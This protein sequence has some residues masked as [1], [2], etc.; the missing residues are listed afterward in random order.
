MPRPQKEH[1]KALVEGGYIYFCKKC[2]RKSAK[3]YLVV[4][5]SCYYCDEGNTQPEFPT[6][7]RRVF[8]RK[9]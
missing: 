5:L 2:G 9:K 4:L 8:K 1:K 6:K 7:K 3:L